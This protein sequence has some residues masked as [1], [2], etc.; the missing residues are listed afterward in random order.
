MTRPFSATRSMSP[1]VSSTSMTAS[2]AEVHTGLPPKVVPWVPGVNS[3]A[4]LPWATTAPSGRPPPRPL[5]SVIT[6]GTMVECWWANQAPVRP[7][8]VCTSSTIIMTP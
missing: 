7:M 1:S 2:A 4:A 5:A 6:S 8:P 3:F